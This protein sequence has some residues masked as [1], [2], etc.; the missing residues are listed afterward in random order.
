MW[1]IIVDNISTINGIVLLLTLISIIWYTYETRKMRVSNESSI[2]LLEK[3]NLRDVEKDKKRDKLTRSY[4]LSQLE[5]LITATA[6]QLKKI[7]N[8]IESLKQDKI[9]NLEFSISIDFNTRRIRIIEPTD[10][11][12]IFVLPSK[13]SNSNQLNSFNLLLRQLDFIDSLYISFNSSFEYMLKHFSE[14]ESKWNENMEITGDYHDKWLADFTREN[15]NPR[16]DPFLNSF[17]S[18]Y[19][20]WASMPDNLD[21]YNAVP[22]LIEPVLQRARETQPNVYGEA[23]FRPLL[24]CL[25]AFANHKNLRKIKIKEYEMYKGQLEEISSSLLIISNVFKSDLIVNE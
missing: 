15:I 7:E 19:H 22:S 9:V 2:S 1:Q 5:V 13:D 24:R 18:I 4:I 21:M 12:E 23:M 17:L 14:Y 3:Q 20:H 25:D 6:D 10:V 8:F 16:L 11:F